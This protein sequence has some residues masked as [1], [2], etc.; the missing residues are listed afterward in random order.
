MSY[1][2]GL[3]DYNNTTGVGPT[4]SEVVDGNTARTQNGDLYDEQT[5]DTTLLSDGDLNALRKGYSNSLVEGVAFS[6]TLGASLAT[7]AGGIVATSGGGVIE[8]VAPFSM[9]TVLG[10][11]LDHFVG[12]QF[13]V[14]RGRVYEYH[15]SDT[16]LDERGEWVLTSERWEFQKNMAATMGSVR[17]DCV[18]YYSTVSESIETVLTKRTKILQNDRHTVGN[19]QVKAM[20]IGFSA[21]GMPGGAQPTT[22]FM[23]NGTEMTGSRVTVR[24]KFVKMG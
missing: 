24:G 3:G 9:R 12:W 7:V 16:Y 23:S 1:F 20:G 22:L 13:R 11:N 6:T 10:W 18:Q 21:G 17:R 19:Y 15:T 4:A 14:S 2:A 8:I 5:G